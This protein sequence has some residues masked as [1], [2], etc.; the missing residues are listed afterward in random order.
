MGTSCNKISYD[1]ALYSREFRLAV[2]FGRIT[3]TY[4]SSMFSGFPIAGETRCGDSSA[5]HLS[6][7]LAGVWICR[8]LESPVRAAEHLPGRYIQL[9]G[10]DSHLGGGEPSP[11]SHS[12]FPSL[13]QR[14]DPTSCDRKILGR[15]QKPPGVFGR[16]PH[17]P[18]GELGWLDSE[19]L[20]PT[21]SLL[22][23]LL[24]APQHHSPL[25]ISRN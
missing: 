22:S 11:L 1:L 6:C 12:S 21:G 20:L 14:P 25:T 4:A 3:A 23:F 9:T 5:S 19:N 13:S 15:H 18:P 16:V 2:F 10:W 7:F 17:P 24:L 8:L